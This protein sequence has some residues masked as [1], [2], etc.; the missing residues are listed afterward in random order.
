MSTVLFLT[1]AKHPPRQGG[2]SARYRPGTGN[3]A[4][5]HLLA[6][7]HHP[8]MWWD[9]PIGPCVVGEP[10]VVL[11]RSGLPVQLERATVFAD[12]GV[13]VLNDPAW[14]AAASDKLFQ[15]AQFRARGVPHPRTNEDFLPNDEV[16][17]KPRRGRSGAGVRRGRHRE[18]TV[19]DDELVQEYIEPEREVRA[20][21]VGGTPLAWCRRRPAPGDFR[22]NLAQGGT[23]EPV[24]EV[25]SALTDLAV[26]ATSAVG[27]DIAAVDI[28]VTPTGPLA[29]EVNAA[30]TLFG[31]TDAATLEVLVALEALIRQP[32]PRRRPPGTMMQ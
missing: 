15:A 7:G 21:V 9:H 25:P 13:P 19:G 27:L 8:V 1:E 11:L 5:E 31:P 3:I 24:S 14:H 4:A 18:L 29:L 6:A 23:M 32:L 17:V 30:P 26:A 28:L 20:I 10:D 12:A 2:P 22:A 16:V